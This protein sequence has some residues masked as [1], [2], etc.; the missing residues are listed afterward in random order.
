MLGLVALVFFRYLVIRA[1]WKAELLA[2]AEALD[3]LLERAPL[4]MSVEELERGV[5]ALERL[6]RQLDVVRLPAADHGAPGRRG[7]E[8]AHEHV[9][10]IP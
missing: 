6:H 2:Q 4:Y 1:H 3:A 5:D 10:V 9:V 7:V 8:P